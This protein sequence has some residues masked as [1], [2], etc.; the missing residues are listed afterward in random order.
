[1]T[2]K[3]VQNFA[4]KFQVIAKKICKTSGTNFLMPNLYL[5]KTG[6]RKNS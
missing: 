3:S 4:M 6:N 1:M 2:T 5:Y